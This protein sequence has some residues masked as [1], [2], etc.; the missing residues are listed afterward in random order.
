[1]RLDLFGF[2]VYLIAIVLIALFF[3]TLIVGVYKHDAYYICISILIAEIIDVK[4]KI[5]R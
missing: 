2:I 3:I 5:N 1:M 4:F